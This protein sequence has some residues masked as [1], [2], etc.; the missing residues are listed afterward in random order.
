MEKHYTKKEKKKKGME[1][2]VLQ[3]WLCYQRQ[4]KTMGT[5][6]IKEYDQ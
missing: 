5:F 4:R 1:D 2:H 6:Q 3:K